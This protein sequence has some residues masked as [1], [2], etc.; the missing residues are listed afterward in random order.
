MQKYTKIYLDF[1]GFGLDN[2]IPCQICLRKAE[3]IHHIKYRSQG[4]T[5][6]IEN[7]MAVCTECHDKLH[8]KKRPFIYEKEA[9]RIHLEYIEASKRNQRG[10]F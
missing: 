1:F 3:G 10:F 9:K 8:F 4:G 2:Y 6:D 5:D 7:I